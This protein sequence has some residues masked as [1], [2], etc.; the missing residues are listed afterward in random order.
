MS[1]MIQLSE[2]QF[3]SE[4]GIKVLDDVHLRVDRGELVFL[5]GPAA[6]GK[7]ILLGLVATQIPPQNGQ[8]LVYGRNIARLS[9]KKAFQL[10]RQIGFI[11]QRFSPLPKTVL[12]NV[13][14]KLR[15]LGDFR[16]QAEEKA[17]AAL[18]MVS[19]TRK[20]AASAT[21]IEPIDRVR[22]AF[23]V[24]ICNDPLLL[25]FDEPFEELSADDRSKVCS[26]L[27][28]IHLRGFTILVTTRNPL[29]SLIEK[30]RVVHLLDG[31]VKEG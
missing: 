8:I 2:L 20:L 1:V 7:T 23:A 27:E 11:P 13:I 31:K 10:R 6:A 9:R 17:L 5:T 14:F 4:D 26:L 24:A 25:L 30:Y 29:P 15:T 22:L 16:E 28:E 3:L 12:D 18:E 19:L 21:E